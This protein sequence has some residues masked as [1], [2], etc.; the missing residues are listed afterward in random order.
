MTT[1][2]LIWT[3]AFLNKNSEPLLLSAVMDYVAHSGMKDAP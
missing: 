2:S 3:D 1:L